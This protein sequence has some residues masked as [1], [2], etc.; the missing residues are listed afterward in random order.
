MDTSMKQILFWISKGV[1][2]TMTGE[3]VRPMFTVL[4]MAMALSCSNPIPPC[5]PQIIIN[6]CR[7]AHQ[8]KGVRKFL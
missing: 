4:S 1:S 5:L 7:M 8:S 6:K 3:F 2:N